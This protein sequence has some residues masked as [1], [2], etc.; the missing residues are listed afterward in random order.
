MRKFFK[1]IFILT[2]SLYSSLTLF[3]IPALPYPVK[4][5]QPDGSELTIQLRGDEFFHYKTT[6]DGYL[7]VPDKNGVFNY[8]VFEAS[9][10]VKNTGIKVNEINKRKSKE[11]KFIK[12]LSKNIDLS[13]AKSAAR[14]ARFSKVSSA[15]PSQKAYPLTGT[16]KSLVILV[17]FSDK[18]FITANPQT[19][20][21]DLLNQEGYSANGGTGSARDYFH[22]AS[23]GLFNPQFDVAGPYTLPHN[24]A[25]YGENDTDDQD[26][27]PRQMVIDACVLADASGVD[28]AQYDTDNDGY[29]D[30]IFIYYAGYNEAENA[31]ANTIWPHRWA[32]AN[33][34]TLFDG[35]I[36]YDYACTSELRGKSG[37]NMCGIG[38][39]CH[40]FGHVLGLVDYYATNNST[41][42][43]LSY[44]N[45]MDAGAYLNLGRTPPTYSAYDRFYLNW[46][47]PIELK[48]KQEVTL[49][50]L[51]ESNKSYIITQNGNHNLN[52]SNPDPTEFFTLENR[53][54]KGWDTYLPGHGLI[55]TRINY[56]V[57][58]WSSNTPNN[59][60]L[61]MGVYIIEAD[62]IPSDNSLPG[63]PFPGT[64]NITSYSPTLRSG[65]MINKPLTFIKEKDGVISFRF[66]GG[67]R[68]PMIETSGNFDLF[69]TVQGTPSEVQVIKV[70]GKILMDSLRLNFYQN[71]HYEMR[72]STE[73]DSQWRKHIALAA[74]DSLVDTTS[75]FIRYNP[76]EPSFADTHNE[77]LILTSEN[78][79]TIK[80]LIS[81]KSSRPVY[82]IPP[83][84][85]EAQDIT[86][87]SFVANWNPVYDAS[88]YYLTVYSV[89]DGESD[90]TEGFD[91]GLTAPDGWTI[92]AGA[93]TT[94]M[95]FSG[96]TIPAIQF[97]NTGDY[98]LT[99]EYVIP[100]TGLS[101][102]VKSMS[103][104]NGQLLVEAWNGSQ[105]EVVE[106]IPVTA[107]L[108]GN[109]TY[110]FT[111]ENN[112]LR[113]R[114]S[115]TKSA[116]YLAID[117]ISAKFP[118]LIDYIKANKW[119]T[120]TSDT[121]VNLISNRLHYYKVKASDRTI[122]F[123][124][125]ILYE[126]ITDFSNI[127]EVKTL[128]DKD[129]NTLRS[130]VQSD[131]SVKVILPTTHEKV[132][133]FNVIGQK[134]R[135]IT[136]NT[137]ILSIYDLPANHVY[138]LQAGKR[139]AKIIL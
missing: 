127:V 131:G 26:K 87:G 25:F 124:H 57:S 96:D 99:E 106:N 91:N 60:P 95:A 11:K 3:A 12:T 34:S 61:A 37:S 18:D 85:N 65:T 46:L 62:E 39:F 136:P 29:V 58:T 115:F 10:R 2:A 86:L 125:T 121:I 22:D 108:S 84:A 126:N 119:T 52:G 134:L 118:K 117:D 30:N 56:N 93:T 110:S 130:F 116:G 113:F 45:I 13:P 107:S 31:P 74:V 92:A 38:T 89:S 49:D 53:Q 15:S 64:S 94:S 129:I 67:G 111:N 28:F 133:V 50:A 88:G 78:A 9:G 139:R 23:N 128:E 59:D 105:W 70:Y 122:D 76:T 43:T 17:N 100:V 72:L 114:F 8:G 123:A 137:N 63:D 14:S 40:E 103:E 90:K 5:T 69:N 48:T 98:I 135:E 6:L 97:R 81:G 68:G 20:F 112:Y 47:I 73:T 32:L 51:T 54:P 42:H 75:V 102:F 1:Y 7:I 24:F 66:M 71:T 16:P 4:I 80:I 83:I 33:T 109:K 27:N 101:F 41:H 36:I 19:A 132:Y 44:W 82:V 104:T 55:I 79:E 21:T 120:A 138:I 35:K 77:T